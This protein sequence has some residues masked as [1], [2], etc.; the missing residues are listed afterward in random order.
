MDHNLQALLA[1]AISGAVPRGVGLGS[2]LVEPPFSERRSPIDRA[3][4][5]CN[6]PCALF[7][8]IASTV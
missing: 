8:S 6:G 4:R 3:D 7:D 2:A 1:V 5:V